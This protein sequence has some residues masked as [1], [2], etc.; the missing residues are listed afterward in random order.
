MLNE[1][2]RTELLIGKIGMERLR[3]ASVMVF[4]VGGV[5][6]HCIEALARSGVGRL[7]LIDN[8]TVSLTN[9]NRQSI[10]YHS[11]IGRYKTEVMKERIRDIN[12]EICVKT[13]EMFVLP[14]NLEA[15]FEEKPDY[16]IDAIDTVTAKL[17]LVELALR[18]DIPVISSMGTGNKLHPEMFE[19]TDLSKT[20][21]CPLCK[22]MR[23]ELK[24][25][26][27]YHLKVLYSREKPIDTSERDTGED[28]GQRRSIPGSISFV[29]PAAGLLIAGEALRDIIEKGK[30]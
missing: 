9:I 13:Y 11:T 27:I 28:K 18:L 24:A 1:Y 5:G 25:R 12:P 16:V 3:A 7:T 20:S 17:A 8:D 6:S 2:S 21:V 15:L 22:V 10:A 29:P 30:A 23:K 19:I 4:G 26:G 14:D